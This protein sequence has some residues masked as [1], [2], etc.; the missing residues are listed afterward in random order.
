M[1]TKK[2]KTIGTWV[3]RTEVMEFFNYKS[4]QMH[5]FMKEYSDILIISR[6]GRRCFIDV[7]SLERLLAIHQESSSR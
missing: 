7:R 6:I 1:E 3:N 4:T 5:E 2:L